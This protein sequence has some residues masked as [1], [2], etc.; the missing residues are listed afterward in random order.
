MTD[1]LCTALIHL[2]DLVPELCLDYCFA[3]G[4]TQHVAELHL[5]RLAASKTTRG[6]HDIGKV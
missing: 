5:Q 1:Y 6:Y 2:P 4:L 3:T